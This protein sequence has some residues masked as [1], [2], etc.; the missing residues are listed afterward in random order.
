MK[1]KP[2]LLLAGLVLILSACNNGRE[3]PIPK[4]NKDKIQDVKK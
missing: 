1:H 2:T 4:T 3:G